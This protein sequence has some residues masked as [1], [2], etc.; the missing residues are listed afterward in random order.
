[1]Q[2]THLLV[3]LV[4]MIGTDC[5]HYSLGGET[6]VVVPPKLFVGTDLAVAMGSS[7]NDPTAY[8]LVESAPQYKKRSA[9][10]HLSPRIKDGC[11][12]APPSILPILIYL[13]CLICF[14]RLVL[15]SIILQN[16][17]RN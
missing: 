9:I 15:L 4:H 8:A 1:M 12:Y 11:R 3:S 6:T 16:R 7:V 10:L 2:A 13:L 5:T 17:V 14:F